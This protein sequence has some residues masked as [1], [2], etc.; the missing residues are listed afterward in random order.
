MVVPA[1]EIL[2]PSLKPGAVLLCDNVVASAAGYKDFFAKIKGPG[3]KYKT[4]TLP[5]DGG[6]EMV[7]YWP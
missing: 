3:S 1:F 2:E 5:Y 6:L 7:T 4:V